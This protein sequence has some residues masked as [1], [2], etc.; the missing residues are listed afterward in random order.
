MAVSSYVPVL[1]MELREASA[2]L[3]ALQLVSEYAS[4]FKDIRYT[5]HPPDIPGETAGKGSNLAWAARSVWMAMR[6]AGALA[7]SGSS[8]MREHDPSIGESATEKIGFSRSRN[9]RDDRER[10]VITVMDSDS[11]LLF[12]VIT[13]SWS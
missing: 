9:A 1:G 3:K 8:R 2:S 10:T 12:Y 6:P 4:S 5:L 13:S 7:G 11:K